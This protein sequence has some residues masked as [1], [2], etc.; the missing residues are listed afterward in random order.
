MSDEL[1]ATPDIL[2]RILRRKAEE[3]IE[4]AERRSLRELAAQVEDL[5]PTRGFWEALAERL[6]AGQPAVIAELKRA[7]P[8]KG[9]IR[10]DYD[11]DAIAS[12]YANSGA[13]CLSVLTDK[14][15][16]GGDDSHLQ[17]ARN[18]VQLP[19][20]RKDFTIDTYQVY[21]ARVLGA[22]CI[23]LIAAALGD[24]QLAELHALALE[25][26]LDVLIE[27][28]DAEELERVAAFGPG[29]IGINNRD[30][31]TFTTDLATTE[32]LAPRV[33]ESALTVT[34]SGIHTSSDVAR[35]RAAGVHSFLVGEAFMSA[36]SPGQKLVEL[37]ADL[38]IGRL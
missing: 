7:S 5:P 17:A 20:L 6:D 32:G 33:P 35:I 29:L 25:L 9:V 38:S 14:D 26:G 37:F 13:A 18:A 36:P 12:D 21:E 31:H 19:V 16:F 4:R 3:V 34:E 10:A 27:V 1:S 30:L 15:F 24:A 2:R 23:L 8:S 11:P 22:D 28:H